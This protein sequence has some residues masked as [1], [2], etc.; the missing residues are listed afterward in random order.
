MDDFFKSKKFKFLLALFV[1]L[2]TFV[3]R[4][5]WTGGLSPMT[6]QIL[7][8]ISAPFQKVSAKISYK[9]SD[10]FS[11]FVKTKEISKENDELKAKVE[12]LNKKVVDY[13]KFKRENEHLK[14]FLQ[15][16]EQNPEFVFETAT[17]IGRDANSRFH[18]F[19]IDKGTLNGIGIRDTVITSKGIVGVVNEVGLTY[20][21]VVTI[22]DVSLEIG[23]YIS[24]T[25]DVG[26][27]NG[28]VT[29]AEDGN[30]ILTLLPRETKAQKG[31][32]VLTSGYGGLY[33]KDIVVG[34]IVEIKNETH[35][36]SKYAVIKPSSDIKNVKDVLVIK[37]FL[38]E[39][40]DTNKDDNENSG[41][42]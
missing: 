39:E 34:E 36:L 30:T 19:T 29:A 24:S 11:V 4:A 8:S 41:K 17:V 35:G 21:K 3:L 31:D 20:S 23:S 27:V 14:K 26:I 16:K 32:I 10:F 15:I 37:S 5:A 40:N 12:E 18:S 28:K 38:G 22:L 9:L 25:R 2:I 6:S 42:D 1:I 7:G 33:P 13:D